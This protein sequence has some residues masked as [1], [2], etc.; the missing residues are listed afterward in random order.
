MGKDA[1]HLCSNC[2]QSPSNE[3][4]SDG[5]PFAKMDELVRKGE[6]I[7]PSNRK[8]EE[9]QKARDKSKK[10]MIKTFAYAAV[11]IALLLV[12][13]FL[14]M[15]KKPQADSTKEVSKLLVAAVPQS[16]AA[17]VDK[18]QVQAEVDKML[19]DTHQVFLQYASISAYEQMTT[20]IY[21]S[22]KQ[23]K[24]LEQFYQFNSVFRIDPEGVEEM[25]SAIIPN[26]KLKG[27][28]RRWKV[29]G[30]VILDTVFWNKDGV[31]YLDWAHF[32][33]YSSQPFS[34][35]LDGMGDSSGE[36]RVLARESLTTL[37]EDEKFL[38]VV[39]YDPVV[40]YPN[41]RNRQSPQINVARN[42]PEGIKLAKAF[43]LKKKGSYPFN[44]GLPMLES[45]NLIRVCIK[46]S[47][48]KE[49]MLS[50]FKIDELK[51]CHWMSIDEQGL[52]DVKIPTKEKF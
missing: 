33:R 6:R 8:R 34:R 37:K 41:Q 44:N 22:V 30:G 36:F 26:T 7:L 18:A 52:E 5:K 13:G 32:M 45:D 29:A 1:Q 10:L 51:A 20:Y 11:L 12:T 24:Y 28:E 40:G 46:M 25:S 49:G 3:S 4:V 14:V 39:F 47:R 48:A 2:G 19:E 9:A 35:F 27:I 42:S 17:P 50:N 21:D 16:D 43:E 15:N 38:K 31:W 23:T